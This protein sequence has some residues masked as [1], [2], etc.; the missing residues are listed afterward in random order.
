MR[1]D[2]GLNRLIDK[3]DN[4]EEYRMA[5]FRKIPKWGSQIFVCMI[6]LHER[7]FGEGDNPENKTPLLLCEGSCKGYTIHK[8]VCMFR[9]R[10]ATF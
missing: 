5:N 8:F 10:E 9:G 3:L 1:T 2:K 4:P 6:C 7:I